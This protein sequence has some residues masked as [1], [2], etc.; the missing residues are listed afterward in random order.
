M[1]TS[2][3]YSFTLESSVGYVL[4]EVTASSK[5]TNT[6][7]I[8]FTFKF[9]P[10]SS[11]FTKSMIGGLWFSV[12]DLNGHFDI[13]KDVYNG[14][15]PTLKSGITYTVGTETI[16]LTCDSVGKISSSMEITVDMTCDNSTTRTATPSYSVEVADRTGILFAESMSAT[17]GIAKS[18][19]LISYYTSFRYTLKYSLPSAPNYIT[20]LSKES[21]GTK[22]LI[23]TH[24]IFDEASTEDIF[25]LPLELE[26]YESESATTPIGTQKYTVIVHLNDN[27]VPAVDSIVA[28]EP[29]RGWRN[30][31][32]YV[33]LADYDSVTITPVLSMSI[34]EAG[35]KPLYYSV[36]VD[37]TTYNG[38]ISQINGV[39]NPITTNVLHT[40]GDI[41]ITVNVTDSRGRHGSNT[42]TITVQ[43]YESP[44]ISSLTA[45]RTE[46]GT[47][48][49]EFDEGTFLRTIAEFSCTSYS[50]DNEIEEA[51]LTIKRAEEPAT[52]WLSSMQP[53]TWYTYENQILKSSAYYIIL[54]I[55]D[56][57]GVTV[58]M[59]AIVTAVT[60]VLSFKNDGTGVAIG[61]VSEIDGFY[62]AWDALFRDVIKQ[63]GVL[64]RITPVG[65]IQ[66][67]AGNVEDA[68]NVPSGWLVCDGGVFSSNDYP[69]LADVLGDIYGTHSGI[70]YYLPD[71]RGRTIIGTGAGNADGATNHELGNKGGDENA[72]LVTHTHSITTSGEHTHSIAS[73]GA[74]THTFKTQADC[75]ASGTKKGIYSTSDGT[76]T[77]T[78]VMASS[79]AHAHS[80][81]SSGGHSH[82]APAPT[83]AVAATGANMQPFIALNYII[84]AK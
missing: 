80:I 28:I 26:T 12:T 75:M 10:T 73:S 69:K 30:G 34:P 9:K 57:V 13:F 7:T 67:Y 82:T 19:N 60:K 27:V 4:W 84:C 43:K 64:G 14:N 79:G 78:A 62:C 74:H 36:T 47:E 39:A 68:G 52:E 17:S 59:Q 35:G 44:V 46:T 41:P 58:S 70:S 31:D 38:T 32:D 50:G 53:E 33:V 56:G 48:S 25:S 22:Q 55:T 23:F 66:P 63:A 54:D 2:G 18:F 45:F 72:A 71:M 8:K 16:T 49:V 21:G 24:D 1:A 6:V 37:G 15:N 76:W 11:K 3:S 51:R 20:M 61:S 65:S 77:G 40:V 83:G 81:T 5:K 29:S 42:K